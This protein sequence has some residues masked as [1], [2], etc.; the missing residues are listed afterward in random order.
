MI[1]FIPK[2]ERERIRKI[3]RDSLEEFS[4]IY[5]LEKS[6]ELS[7]KRYNDEIKNYLMKTE[8][9]FYIKDYIQNRS[10]RRK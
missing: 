3:Y 10:A 6:K 7:K 1:E 4:A 2:E 8:G 9:A 5:N